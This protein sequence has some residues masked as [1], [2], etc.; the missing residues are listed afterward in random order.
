MNTEL[1]RFNMVEQQIRT[2]NVLDKRVLNL[3]SQLD[4]ELFVPAAYAALAYSDVEIPLPHG[5]RMNV[6]RVDARLVQDLK[7]M[8]HESVLEVGTGSGYLTALLALSV[9]Q[10]ISLECH[11][12]LIVSAQQHLAQ[13]GVRNAQIRHSSG[14]PELKESFDAIVLGGSVSD[15]PESMFNMLKPGGRLW[16][17]VGDEPMMQATLFTRIADHGAHRQILW[18][19]VTPRLHGFAQTPAFQF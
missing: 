16:A 8:P 12:D 15:V 19:V 11:A 18:D 2:W 6:P 14:V 3:L 7:L 4:R 9:Q 5:E 1:A 17:V 13:A 10:V